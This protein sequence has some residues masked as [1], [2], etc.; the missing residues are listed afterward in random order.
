MV[1]TSSNRE[2][3]FA[4]MSWIVEGVEFMI[5]KMFQ[6]SRFHIFFVDKTG[7]DKWVW[8]LDSI[9]VST[10]LGLTMELTNDQLHVLMK[11]KQLALYWDQN[12]SDS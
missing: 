4:V 10:L 11:I 8:H 9:S 3:T 1:S 5:S 2:P 7:L 12:A 6:V